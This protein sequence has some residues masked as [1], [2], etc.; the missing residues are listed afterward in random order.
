VL[1][2]F[3]SIIFLSA[4]SPGT[5]ICEELSVE[6]LTAA[7]AAGNPS[8][9]QANETLTRRIGPAEVQSGGR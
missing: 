3:G 4:L 6:D 8:I 9:A 2:G 1:V 7:I 5:L